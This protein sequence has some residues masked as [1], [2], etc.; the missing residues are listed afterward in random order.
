M[1]L[2]LPIQGGFSD[3]I[4]RMRQ[5]LSDPAE[6]GKAVLESKKRDHCIYNADDVGGDCEND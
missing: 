1:A 2:I 6:F 3:A 4:E 5:I